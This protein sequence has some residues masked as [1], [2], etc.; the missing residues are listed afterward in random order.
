MTFG[1]TRRVGHLVCSKSITVGNDVCGPCISRYH[2]NL[3]G[4]VSEFEAGNECQIDRVKIRATKAL[5][6]DPSTVG[7][8]LS[9]PEVG[10]VGYTSDT[11]YFEGV[12]YEYK[13][14]DLLILCTMRPRGSPWK[15]HMSTDDAVKILIEAKPKRAI[16]THFGLKML[17]SNPDLEAKYVEKSTNI[18]TSA[19]KDG[20]RVKMEKRSGDELTKF[21]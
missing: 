12:G 16:L 11:E 15:G 5:H 17:T 6:S 7:F 9:F 4:K 2:K 3:L 19:A 8:I 10:V 14:V 20:M 1:A 21:F 13:G 18:P